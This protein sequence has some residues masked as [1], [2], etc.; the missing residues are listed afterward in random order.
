MYWI[1]SFAL[2]VLTGL[3]VWLYNRLKPAKPKHKIPSA[4][5]RKVARLEEYELKNYID[6]GVAK[7]KLYSNPS[8]T[9]LELADELGLS[10]RHLRVIIQEVHNQSIAEYLNE[11]RIQAAC[12]LLREQ[13]SMTPEEISA[14]TGFASLPAFLSAFKEA[15]GQTPDEYRIQ[16]THSGIRKS[17]RM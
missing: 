10:E 1:I 6:D 8:I 3:V 11:R 7:N 13:S 15:M 16:M 4:N 2:F 9:D 14:E 17:S 12:R 5:L